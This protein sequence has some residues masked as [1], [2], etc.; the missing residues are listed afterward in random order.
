[1]KAGSISYYVQ[2]QSVR[3]F[4]RRLRSES[5]MEG[6]VKKAAEQ[7]GAPETPQA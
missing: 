1:M 4:E 6:I 7:Q 3:P 5:C 2:K